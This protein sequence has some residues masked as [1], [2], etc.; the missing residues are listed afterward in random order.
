MRTNGDASDSL[1]A[2][3]AEEN[4][5]RGS[6][7]KAEEKKGRRKKEI[8]GCFFAKIKRGDKTESG[9]KIS[10]SDFQ[11]FWVLEIVASKE[12]QIIML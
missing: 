8:A 4:E 1:R 3:P 12:G 9:T 6:A 11:E 2:Q 10:G 5:S 7:S